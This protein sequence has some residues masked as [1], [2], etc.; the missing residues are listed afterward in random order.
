MRWALK[1]GKSKSCGCYQKENYKK[2]F[3]RYNLTGEYGIGYTSKGEEFYFDLEDYDKIKNYTWTCNKEGYLLSDDNE[4][5][6]RMH[7]LIMNCNNGKVFVD[8]I[9]H[10]VKDNR[11]INL[12][13]VDNSKNQM[14]AKIRSNNSSGYAGVCFRKSTGKWYANI[15]VNKK[16]IQLGTFIKKEDAIK[17]R[18]EAEEKFFGKYS[19]DN[20]LKIVR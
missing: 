18:K 11:R 17:A 3:N 13:L 8:H 19:Y 16:R 9:N 7:R 10:N 5:M 20:S 2:K 4:K 15:Q 12:R 6:I 14:N 1:S